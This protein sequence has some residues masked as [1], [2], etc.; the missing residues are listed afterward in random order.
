V[1][2][3]TFDAAPNPRRVNLFI[4]YK[5]IELPTQQVNLRELEQFG[6]EFKA[7]NPRCIVPALQL[8]DGTVLCDGIA[9]CSYLESV[10][11]EKPLLG[12]TPLLRAQVLSW[13]HQIYADG[14]TPVAEALRNR[15]KAFKDRALPGSDPIAQIPE[16]EA[17]GRY[18]LNLFWKYLDDHLSGRRF[19][20]GDGLTLADIDAVVVIDFAGWIKETVPQ[21]CT[22][23]QMWAERVR[24]SLAL[25]ATSAQT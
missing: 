12:T 19:I 14:F 23:V 5:G 1:K 21:D 22:N 20:V 8:D 3:F 7:V 25:P 9:I 10:Y 17:R 15:S 13:D 6:E 2:L 11:P 4:R 16:L 24:S 18:R